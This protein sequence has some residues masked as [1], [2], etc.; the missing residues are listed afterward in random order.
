MYISQEIWSPVPC[1]LLFKEGLIGLMTLSK[2]T[3]AAAAV[4][5]TKERTRYAESRRIRP[6]L[7]VAIFLVNLLAFIFIGLVY[8]RSDSTF[9]EK[10]YDENIKN[11]ES[12][13]A[14]SANAAYTYTKSMGIKIDDTVS[15]IRL[16]D[17]S[18]AEAV[19][20]LGDSSTNADRQLQL[21]LSGSYGSTGALSFGDYSGVSV[22]KVPLPDGGME[23]VQTDIIYGSGYYEIYAAFT[24]VEDE[25]L[26]GL[27]FTPEFTDPD[28]KQKCFGVYRHVTLADAAG[29]RRLYTVLLAINS[30]TALNAYNMQNEYAG[31]STVLIDED[32]DYIIKSSDYRNAN[33]LDYIVNYNGL[34][35]EQR[36]QLG[37]LLAGCSRETG[38]TVDLFYQN[39]NGDDC[40]F[41]VTVMDNG[42]YSVTCV[43]IASFDL[44]ND[45]V[46][47]SLIILMLFLAL[48]AV[49]AVAIYFVGKTMKYNVAVAKRA[50]EAADQA[51]RAKSR[52]LSTMSHELRTPLNAIIGLTALSRDSIGNPAVLADYLKK[53]DSSS[54]LLLQ[55]IS[56]ILDISAIESDKLKLGISEFDV[57]KLIT[58]LS[59]IYYDQCTA[60]GLEFN[61]V[62]D[63]MHSE[64]LVGDHV[65]VNQILLNFLSNAIKYT[66]SG[67]RV[68]LRAEQV[69]RDGDNVVI[70]FA[71]SD[72]GCGISEEL[73]ARLFKPFERSSGEQAQRAGGTGLGLSI[74]KSLAELMGGGIG[75]ES[76]EGKGSTFWAEL[77]FTVSSTS[78]QHSYS[79]IKGLRVLAA[80]GDADERRHIGRMLKGFGVGYSLAADAGETL[81]LLRDDRD[82]GKPV[83][84]CL[85][86]WKLPDLTALDA[87]AAIRREFDDASL[88]VAVLAYDIAEAR[89]RCAEA[90]AALVLGKPVFPST[91]YNFLEETVTGQARVIPDSTRSYD[92]RGKRALLVEDNAMNLVIA[93]ELLKKVG[94]EVEIAKDGKQGYECFAASRPGHFDVVLMDVQMPVMNGYQATEAI[95]ASAHPQAAAIPILAMTA[96]AFSEDVEKA[97]RAGMNEH[98]AK[99]IE[100][101]TLYSVLSKYL[102]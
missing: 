5:D 12:L 13:N 60:K 42:W 57:T 50:R 43:P 4:D 17:L 7:V 40:V 100:P 8:V 91:L 62:I 61:V 36:T 11:V 102:G 90:G 35:R 84:L 2:S 79:P 32:G 87:A 66:P 59:A 18:Y 56:D 15:Y 37:A 23:T 92:M 34:S 24:D 38:P 6:W 9:R 82:A 89:E 33:F 88:T 27:C 97:R 98:L 51:S 77:P 71:V 101:E 65:R 63:N 47:Y 45:S 68:T 31:Q 85:L 70:R 83:D 69:S 48:F 29:Q 3:I 96:D 10:L 22:R 55:L 99:P 73:S 30:Q 26:H 46:N 25:N 75:V 95:R 1:A 49:D 72:T 78:P 44:Q 58:V 19:R 64:L 14:A 76:E 53:I 21:V 16:N 80:I 20:Y 93:Q 39:H 67:G 81:E 86:D 41:A 52:F 94:L 28:T 74:A 54:K